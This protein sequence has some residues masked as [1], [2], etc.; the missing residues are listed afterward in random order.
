MTKILV[1]AALGQIGTEL[2]LALRQ[3]YGAENVIASD[4]RDV[5]KVDKDF[6]PYE[7]LDV[8]DRVSFAAVI[9]KHDVKVIHHLAAILS[10]AGEKNPQ[11]C[12]DVNITGLYN[13][14][15]VARELVLSKLSAQ[16]QLQF[17]APKHRVTT[18]RSKLS[19]CQKQCMACLKPQES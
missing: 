17:L 9:K 8:L 4:L 2:V 19:F 12:F 7:K 10:A 3:T 1:T 15:E 11:L 18:L 13:V 6:L 16:A 14:L 5:S